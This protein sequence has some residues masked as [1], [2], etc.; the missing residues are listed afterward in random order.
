MSYA[1]SSTLEPSLIDPAGQPDIDVVLPAFNAEDTIRGSLQSILDQ[2]FA[3]FRI[4]V[5]DDGSTDQTASIVAG[6]MTD[7]RIR[8]ISQP[9]G[10]VVDALN[11]GLRCTTAD[12][13]ARFDAD[14]LSYPE[15]F[16]IQL[17]Y[18][19]D[20]ADCVAVGA[21]A[22]HIDG[23]GNRTGRTTT[24]GPLAPDTDWAP[25]REPYL[26]HPFL[27]ARR[28]AMIQV[29]G[30]RHVFHAED[31]DLYWRLQGLGR[32]HNLPDVLGEYRV[33]AGSISSKSIVNGRVLALY[34]QLAALSE[35][36]RRA[37]SVD[38]AFDKSLLEPLVSARTLQAMIDLVAVSL[39]QTERHYLEISTAAKLLETSSYRPFELEVEDCEFIASAIHQHRH[40]LSPEN[41]SELMFRQVQASRRLLAKG[42]W[43]A[44]KALAP[45]ALLHK[46][47]IYHLRL[48]LGLAWGYTD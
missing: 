10:G 47:A 7:H 19:R 36:R 15:R 40:I 29:G 39:T 37:G 48:K 32:L 4:F 31:V 11:A 17:R 18:L 35:R 30:Y 13:I 12:F 46:V 24:F 22:H 8:L 5:V 33:H 6:M 44:F 16:S 23:S 28:D 27:L 14:D 45:A 38:I 42:E 26:M 41:Q 34:G 9:N 2:T 3:S 25:S 1:R 20:H 43:K 21:N